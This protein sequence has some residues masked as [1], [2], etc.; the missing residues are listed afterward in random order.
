M[1][2]Y[3]SFAIQVIYLHELG[4]LLVALRLRLGAT[5]GE[6]ATRGHIYRRRDFALDRSGS[7]MTLVLG[8]GLRVGIHQNLRIGGLRLEKYF[9]GFADFHQT[10]QIHHRHA[11][12]DVAHH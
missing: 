1:T 6:S 12:A 3:H 9:V 8:V 2:C 4:C 7:A 11:V 5:V 10:A